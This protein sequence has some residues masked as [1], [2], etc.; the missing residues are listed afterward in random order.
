MYAETGKMEEVN[1]LMQ[2]LK[3][4]SAN[5]FIDAVYMAIA[6]A[7]SGNMDEAFEY[8]D[9]AIIERDPM[10]ITLKYMKYSTPLRNDPRFKKLVASPAPK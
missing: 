1:I 3:Q 7:H 4:R 10:L 5:E 6:A 9:A 2:E 8:L